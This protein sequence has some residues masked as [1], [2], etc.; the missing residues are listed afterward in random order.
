MASTVFAI[1]GRPNHFLYVTH[2]AL[3][4]VEVGQ[5]KVEGRDTGGYAETSLQVGEEQSE[6]QFWNR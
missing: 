4:R 2:S 6:G 1:K 5:F 3:S